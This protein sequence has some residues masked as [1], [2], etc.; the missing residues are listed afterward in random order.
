MLADFAKLKDE[1]V[2]DAGREYQSQ[3]QELQAS[4]SSKRDSEVSSRVAALRDD[5][6]RRNVNLSAIREEYSSVS[7]RAATPQKCFFFS[8]ILCL[9][10]RTSKR[11]LF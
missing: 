3:W 10:P 4:V 7:S 11:R 1:L 6:K 2:R 9:L 8:K 5:W